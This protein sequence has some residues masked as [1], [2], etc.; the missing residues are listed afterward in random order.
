MKTIFLLAFA[1]VTLGLLSCN[2]NKNSSTQ[3]LV[4]ASEQRDCIGVAP[5]RCYLV[6]EEGQNNWEYFY[7]PI[8]NFDY[9]SGNEYV[10]R[11][12]VA[13]RENPPMDVSSLTYTLEKVVSVTQKQ[14]EGMLPDV[15][16]NRN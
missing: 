1:A 13:K 8:E 15:P 6:K 10:I 5:Q 2:N 16:V 7:S 4:V 12:R 3:T 9:T 11:V 14:S